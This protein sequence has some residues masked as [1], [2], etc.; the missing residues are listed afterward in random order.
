MT[1]NLFE[2]VLFLRGV[3]LNPLAEMAQS[4]ELGFAI[5]KFDAS[6]NANNIDKLIKDLSAAPHHVG[7]AANAA[8]ASATDPVGSVTSSTKP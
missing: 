2:S 5:C 6:L 8:N 3:A 1:N 7:S 4:C